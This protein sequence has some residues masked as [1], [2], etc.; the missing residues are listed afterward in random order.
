MDEK[1]S[2]VSEKVINCFFIVRK[3]KLNLD[4]NIQKLLK[5]K[6]NRLINFKLQIYSSN[7]I[8]LMGIFS[9]ILK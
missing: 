6:K 2:F 5:K 7:S 8:I 3:L 4:K 9:P 1:A